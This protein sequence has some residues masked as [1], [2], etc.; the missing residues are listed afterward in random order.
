MGALRDC[1]AVADSLLGQPINS[2]TA[3]AFVAGGLVILARTDLAWLGWASVGTGIGSFLFHGPMPPFAEWAH[4]TSLAWLLLVVAGIATP[5]ERWTG[6]PGLALLAL[7]IAVVPGLGDPIGATLA[8]VAIGGL[9]LR[10]RSRH[11]FGALGLLAVAAVVGR[12][13]STGGPLCDPESTLQ[14]H[15]LWHLAAATS[16]T[17]FA[18]A[19]TR[20]VRVAEPS[21]SE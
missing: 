18:L 10:E 5:R 4:D 6:L 11:T 15:G 8:V 13:G 12:L 16:V 14:P 1:E 9:V 21:V 7:P 2:L 17:W 19:R 20:A 3:L